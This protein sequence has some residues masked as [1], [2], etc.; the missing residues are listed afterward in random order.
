MSDAAKQTIEYSVYVF[1][2]A[3]SKKSKSTWE[4]VDVTPN[5][6]KALNYAEELISKRAYP[7]VE[8]K[9]KFFDEKNNRTVDVTL[10]VLETK[11]KR[12]L[13]TIEWLAIAVIL[14]AA[15]FGAA[16]FLAA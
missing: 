2:D 16:F 12:A 4:M 11:V 13:D 6:D 7:K 1:H 9:K 3:K 5:M 14:G 15:A 10:K 8:V